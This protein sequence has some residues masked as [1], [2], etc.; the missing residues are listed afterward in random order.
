[1]MFIAAAKW[2]FRAQVIHGHPLSRAVLMAAYTNTGKERVQGVFSVSSLT[3]QCFVLSVSTS[4]APLTPPPEP[5]SLAT[6][7]YTEASGC[8]RPSGHD[9]CAWGARRADRP[10]SSVPLVGE[11]VKCSFISLTLTHPESLRCLPGL[12]LW[13]GGY[14]CYPCPGGTGEKE[15]KSAIR[16][17]L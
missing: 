2:V 3:L 12:V 11:L 9:H 14:R 15:D 7:L 10:L 5:L 16:A 8:C 13:L 1:M 4:L 6:Y 17:K